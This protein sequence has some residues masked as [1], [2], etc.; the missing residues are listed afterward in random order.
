MGALLNA[1]QD[2]LEKRFEE[3]VEEGE[4]DLERADG[5]YPSD[6]T[7]LGDFLNGE[8][9]AWDSPSAA[10]EELARQLDEVEEIETLVDVFE[11]MDVDIDDVVKALNYLVDEKGCKTIAE[12]KVCMAELT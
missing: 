9:D 8:F 1:E 11:E 3:M 7:A 12:A 2:R 10:A 5:D 6:S 4:W